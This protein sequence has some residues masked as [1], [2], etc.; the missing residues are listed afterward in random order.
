MFVFTTLS[1][2]QLYEENRNLLKLT[3]S[4]EFSDTKS[5]ISINTAFATCQIKYLNLIYPDR[6]RVFSYQKIKYY[7]DLSNNANNRQTAKLITRQPSVFII[8]QELSTSSYIFRT[9]DK[10]ISSFLT[11]LSTTQVIN[12]LHIYFSKKLT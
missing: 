4:S 2:Q 1:I 3:Y 6:I 8:I 12:Y 5:L 11:S 7:Y 10:N 9:Y